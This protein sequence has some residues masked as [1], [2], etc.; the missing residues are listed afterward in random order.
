MNKRMHHCIARRSGGWPGR[1][2]AIGLLS[3]VL[4]AGAMAAEP[5]SQDDPLVTLSYL[6]ETFLPQVMADL[7]ERIARHL[8]GQPSAPEEGAV[9]AVVTLSQGQVLTG[10]I[11]CEVLLRIG[12][13]VCAAPSSPGLID[14]TGGAVLNDGAA[15]AVNHLYMMT[16]QGRGVRAESKTVK[17]LVRG[18][19]TVA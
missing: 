9:F 16:V 14:Q 18:T 19:Y 17:L 1:L 10:D 7:E 4:S 6:N 2:A 13:A 5:G 15:L 12:S 11:G 8:G 3:L